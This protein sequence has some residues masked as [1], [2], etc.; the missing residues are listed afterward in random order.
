[1]TTK[2]YTLS[3]AAP[4]IGLAKSTLERKAKN[5]DIPAQRVGIAYSITAETVEAERARVAAKS[6]KKAPDTH[7]RRGAWAEKPKPAPR[8][9][10]T[11][12]EALAATTYTYIWSDGRQERGVARGASPD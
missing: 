5:G 3:E 8:Q 2:L 10:R 9:Q 6:N 7:E 4:I 11:M 1:M 12:A